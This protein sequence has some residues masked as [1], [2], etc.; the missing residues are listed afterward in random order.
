[1]QKAGNALPSW[2]GKRSKPPTGAAIDIA[3]CGHRPPLLPRC[4]S[5][6]VDDDDDDD[7]EDDDNGATVEAA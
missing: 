5:A 6:T 2:D 7:D 1:M 3:V 4:C